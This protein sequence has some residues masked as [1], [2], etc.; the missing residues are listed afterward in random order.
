[1]VRLPNALA[2][3]NF[4]PSIIYGL[5]VGSGICSRGKSPFFGPYRNAKIW[6]HSK[7]SSSRFEYFGRTRKTLLGS[8][9]N[10]DST[11]TFYLPSNARN[12][13][14]QSGHLSTR[15]KALKTDQKFRVNSRQDLLNETKIL[16][17]CLR[18]VR[19]TTT[20]PE[21]TPSNFEVRN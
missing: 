12:C 13:S 20:F 18:I 19:D 15:G 9:P 4:L 14:L 10:E 2:I 8:V 6:A 7:V 3:N 1:M 16:I 11:R 21:T 17:V 5:L